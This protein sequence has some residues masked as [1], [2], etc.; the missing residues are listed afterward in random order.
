MR[1][2]SLVLA[3][4][5]VKQLSNQL[6][7]F[8]PTYCADSRNV[9]L[10]LQMRR[11]G[12]CRKWFNVKVARS[13]Y[14]YPLTLVVRHIVAGE[15]KTGTHALPRYSRKRLQRAIDL[16]PLYPTGIHH[17]WRPMCRPQIPTLAP[18]LVWRSRVM[19]AVSCWYISLIRLHYTVTKKVSFWAAPLYKRVSWCN[20]ITELLCN[21][22]K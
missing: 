19:S 2:S 4:W 5:K 8:H 10:H 12:Y 13:G 9:L 7:N 21:R 17:V 11:V 15:V 22:R 3:F 6:R 1:S 16:L 20:R 18:N 14:E